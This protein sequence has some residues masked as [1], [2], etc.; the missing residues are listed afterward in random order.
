MRNETHLQLGELE[1]EITIDC[2]VY[3]FQPNLSGVLC[4]TSI[5]HRHTRGKSGRKFKETLCG[6]CMEFYEYKPNTKKVQTS[7]D[8]ERTSD[9][10]K[11]FAFKGEQ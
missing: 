4:Q 6:K 5:K 1:M 3:C 11:T 2:D 9:I 10:G 7:A 8:C